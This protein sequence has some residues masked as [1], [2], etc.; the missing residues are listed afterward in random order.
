MRIA[1]SLMVFLLIFSAYSGWENYHEQNHTRNLVQNNVQESWENNPDKHPHRMAHYG[2]FALR[3]KH[4]LSIFDLGMEN[5]VGNALFLEA[6]KQNTVN[7]SEASM[8]TGL[9]RFGEVSLAMLL[10]VIVPLLIFYLGFATLA[11]EREHGTLKLLIGQGITRKE[12]VF[13]K[14]LGL[15][16]LSLIFLLTVFL[17]LFGFLFKESSGTLDTDSLYRY[18]MLVLSYLLFFS[19][20]SAITI[21]V[22]AFSETAKGAL[23]KLLSIWLLFIIIIPKSL[24]AFGYYLYPTPSKIEMETAIEH[25]LTQQGDSHNPEDPHFKSLKDSV[26][27][28]HDLKKVEDL[29]F[30]FSGFIMSKGEAISSKIYLEHQK[31]LY[32]VYRKQNNIER[33]SAFINPYT[34]IK[35]LSTAFSGTDFQSFLHFKDKAETYR[36]KLAQNMNQLQMDFIP[37][38]GKSGPQKISNKYWKEFPSFEYHFLKINTVFKNELPS[39]IALFLW[40]I[41]VLFGLLKLSNKL[42]AI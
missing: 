40:E 9:L 6:H 2:S 10:K 15:W 33:Y 12:I 13:G 25:D 27:L 22:S 3:I 28:A 21:L 5:F 4:L 8:S 26:L 1:L 38:K 42:K 41:L 39:L 14:W 11:R 31:Q 29:P 34:A 24:H 17:V 37:N 35:N 32:K 30:N 20:L 18:G 7:F 36:F 19:I 16:S 23:I